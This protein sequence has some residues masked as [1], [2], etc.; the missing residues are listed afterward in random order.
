MQCLRYAFKQII[1]IMA[2]GDSEDSISTTI[3]MKCGVITNSARRE[4]YVLKTYLLLPYSYVNLETQIQRA[5][6][7]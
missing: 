6:C 5:V 7:D 4:C 1:I 3:F 2:C